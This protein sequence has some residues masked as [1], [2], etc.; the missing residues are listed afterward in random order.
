MK[1]SIRS[2][3][4][5][6][7]EP[8]R[9][10]S[11]ISGAVY[12][13]FSADGARGAGDQGVAGVVVFI[14][15]NRDGK[16]GT[17]E[18]RATTDENGDFLFEGLTSG[19]YSLRQVLPE[20]YRLDS[21]FARGSQTLRLTAQVA[22]VNA[23]IRVQPTAGAWSGFGKDA[24][25]SALS[26]VASQS[27]D[28]I[29]WQ[30]P[31]DLQPDIEGDVL[32][33]H[34]GAPIFTGNNVV[35]LPVKTEGDE[36]FKIEGRRGSD[37]ALLWS[38]TSDYVMPPHGAP[39]TFNPCVT[40]DNRVYFP[41]IG[42]RIGYFDNADE[43]GEKTVKSLAFYGAAKYA[44][45][46]V[47]LNDHV[48]IN[49][50]LTLDETGN[51][52]FGV[53]SD[54]ESRVIPK[55]GL[56]R[57]SARGAGRFIQVARAAKDLGINR[58][59]QNSAPAL[60]PD[61]KLIYIAAR[62]ARNDATASSPNYLLALNSATLT[63]IARAPLLDPVSGTAAIISDYATSS[64]T[65]GPD[66]D[67]FYGVRDDA[68]L[69]HGRGWLLHFDRKLTR[70]KAPGAFGWDDTAS[71]VPASM[72]EDYTGPS[73]YLLLTKYNHYVGNGG[74]GVN[75]LAVLDP[76]SLQID[77]VTSAI[78]MLEVRTIAGLTADE[79]YGQ[80]G[81]VRE[82]CIN[83]AAVDPFTGSVL[84]NSEDGA[85]YRWNLTSNSFTQILRLT[86]GLG[87]AY[88]PTVI[89][90]DGSVYCINEGILFCIGEQNL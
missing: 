64:P 29:R 30:T 66:G 60:S 24:Q 45:N 74:D 50:P 72:I 76:N 75:K 31:V 63:P 44:K 13:D 36:G 4:L 85:M 59:P 26:G 69:N 17:D 70:V 82:W 67:V 20:G 14:D 39:L 2:F 3:E 12:V 48:S 41:M 23:D 73:K 54:G 81:A 8:R 22:N 38:V 18:P 83:T 21:P 11:A 65:V 53:Q 62:R 55:S 47:D 5:E 87:E 27:L 80:P 57:V 40:S 37:G 35:I 7:C 78:T 15:R 42:G 33:T 9:F 77:P 28:Q 34:Y 49:T 79:E 43:A 1:F 68:N 58:I 86:E 56:A 52:Y 90:P 10:L 6:A 16:P 89:G 88:T 71:I 51:V 84:A 32:A 19:R 46:S 25:H 61:G